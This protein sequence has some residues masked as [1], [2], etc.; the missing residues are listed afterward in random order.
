MTIPILI[1]TLRLSTTQSVVFIR[2]R[3]YRC[4]Y[5][6]KHWSVDYWWPPLA[7]PLPRTDCEV[8]WPRTLFQMVG[9]KCLSPWGRFILSG[10]LRIWIASLIPLICHPVTCSKA[11]ASSQSM[12][13]LVSATCWAMADENQCSLSDSFLFLVKCL[14]ATFSVSFL[15]SSTRLYKGLDVSPM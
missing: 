5:S 2:M 15:C 7:P 12:L 3:L 1:Y 10:V 11:E 6:L 4:N 13:W 8:G 14:A 9:S